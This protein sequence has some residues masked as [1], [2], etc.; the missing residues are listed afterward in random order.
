MTSIIVHRSLN[1]KSRALMIISDAA[2]DRYLSAC[3]YFYAKSGNESS[4]PSFARSVEAAL[5]QVVA[6]HHNDK[7]K[8]SSRRYQTLFAKRS[9]P[10]SSRPSSLERKTGTH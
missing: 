5:N 2:V 4:R 1:R 7:R 9:R 6:T 8:T 10:A 3:G